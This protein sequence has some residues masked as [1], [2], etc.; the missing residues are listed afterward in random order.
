MKGLFRQAF[1]KLGPYDTLFDRYLAWAALLFI[2]VGSL[3]ILWLLLGL[4][5]YSFTGF[6]IVMLVLSVLVAPPLIAHWRK[7]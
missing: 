4:L 3:F 7:S 6:F 5:F 2:T 1:G